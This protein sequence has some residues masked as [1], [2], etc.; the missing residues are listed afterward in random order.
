MSIKTNSKHR[1]RPIWLLVGAL[2]AGAGFFGTTEPASAMPPWWECTAL[3]GAIRASQHGGELS[4][5]PVYIEQYEQFCV[6]W[7]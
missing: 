1:R 5:N 2:T 7:E 6:G 4:G 3:A